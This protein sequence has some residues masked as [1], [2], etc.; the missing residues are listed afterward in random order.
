MAFK[1]NTTLNK[2]VRLKQSLL[3]NKK[4]FTVKY[5]LIK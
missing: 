3:N 1:L 4:L 5:T 2:Q